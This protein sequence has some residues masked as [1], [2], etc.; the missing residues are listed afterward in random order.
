MPEEEKTHPE[1]NPEDSGAE[2]SLRRFRRLVDEGESWEEQVRKEEID[3]TG[4]WYGEIEHPEPDSPPEF[5]LPSNEEAPSEPGKGTDP[6]PPLSLS[7]EDSEEDSSSTGRPASEPSPIQSTVPPEDAYHSRRPPPP[8]LGTTPTRVP[9]A[10]DEQNMPLPK[11]VDQID[12]GATR[13]SPSAF[14]SS[15]SGTQQPASRPRPGTQQRPI[16][17]PRQGVQPRPGSPAPPAGSGRPP[18]LGVTPTT[19][20][21]PSTKNRERIGCLIRLVIASLFIGIVLALAAGSFILYQYYQIARGLPDVEALKDKASTFETTR[22]LDRNGDLLYEIIDP[23]AGRRTYVTLEEMSPFVIATTLATED[24]NYYSH[25]G[26]DP[27]AIFR[28]F[29]QNWQ[30]GETVSGASTITQQVA[31][32]LLF[33]PD[34][35]GQRT[36]LRKVREALLAEEI[37]RR[38]TKDEIL[39]LYINENNYGNLAYGIEAAAQTYFGISADQLTLGQAAFLTGLPQAP[40]VYDIYNNREVT[41]KRLS[42][43]LLLTFEA[44]QEQTCIFVGKGRPE[45]CV[46]AVDISTALDEISQLEFRS[47]DF[48]IRYPHWVNFIRQQ[49]ETQFDTATIYRSGFTV[50]TTLDPV[51][52][53]QAQQLVAAQVAALADKNA[54]NGAL[55]ALNPKTGEI[56]AMVGSPDFYNDDIDGQVN[57][58]IAPRQPGSSIKPLTYVAAF[59][60]GW[61]PSTLLWDVPSEFTPSGQI[62]DPGPTYKPVNYDGRFHGPVTVRAALANSYNVPAVKALNFIGVYGDGGLVPMAQRLGITT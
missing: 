20:S 32:N 10:L 16:S 17:Q 14:S 25:P 56:L 33:D 46:T 61:T 54:H 29:W 45:V 3:L 1:N 43:V 52:Q 35:R 13:V 9:P 42:D 62:N 49:L 53:D 48:Q 24:K 57:M 27:L 22:I 26:F 41:L 5:P 7:F 15:R 12:V 8:P 6:E 19:S 40:S 4:G 55:V 36:Y 18:V 38:Y 58:A 21:Q 28:A 37:N 60:K 59:E 51:W 30:S 44:S 23:N 47:P 31:R 2:E 11:R 50:Y 39:E 34:E